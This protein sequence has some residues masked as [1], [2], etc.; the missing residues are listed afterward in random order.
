M[1]QKLYADSFTSGSAQQGVMLMGV[2]TVQCQG[3]PA[4]AF[5]LRLT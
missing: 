4:Y 3:A 2:F 5:G 1:C